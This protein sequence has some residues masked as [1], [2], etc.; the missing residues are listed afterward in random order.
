TRG[1]VAVWAAVVIILIVGFVPLP[2][3]AITPPSVVV[4]PIPADEVRLCAGAALRLGDASG[5][6][7]GSAI[8]LGEPSVRSG[9]VGAELRPAALPTTDA[10]TGGTSAAPQLFVLTP[11]PDATLAAAQSQVVDQEGFSGFAAT[12]CAEPSGSVW[13]VGG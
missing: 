2:T 8:A 10:G 9:S 4:E 11:A 1:T 6:N 7:A 13:L 5:Q 12:A 3:V